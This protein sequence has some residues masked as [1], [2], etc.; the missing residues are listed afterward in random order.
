MRYTCTYSW[1]K[2]VLLSSACLLLLPK[3]S[4]RFSNEDALVLLA[5]GACLA[6]NVDDDGGVYL[7]VPFDGE[8]GVVA[9]V[10]VSHGELVLLGCCCCCC[11]FCRSTKESLETSTGLGVA[12]EDSRSANASFGLSTLW[13]GCCLE[14]EA[15]GADQLKSSKSSMASMLYFEKK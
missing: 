8:S 5:L 1:F 9:W 12:D 3:G 13:G 7:G 4:S 15:E 2:G 6:S 11:S 10:G 14:G